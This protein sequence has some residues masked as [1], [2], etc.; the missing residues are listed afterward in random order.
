MTITVLE[1]TDV[2]EGTGD[3]IYPAFRR[4]TAQALDSYVQVGETGSI[5]AVLIY[6]DSGSTGI[7]LRVCTAS[8]AQAATQSDPYIGPDESA[9]FIVARKD[10][11]VATAASQL[12]V[13]ATADT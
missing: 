3:P 2:N 6:N 4:R 9:Y 10:R 1:F 13:Y 5:R 12:W 11:T 7:H 8:S